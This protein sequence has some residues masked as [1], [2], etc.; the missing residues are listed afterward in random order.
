ME[1]TIVQSGLRRD[2]IRVSSKELGV[3]TNII[4]RAPQDDEDSVDLETIYD[5][6]YVVTFK[7]ADGIR[8]H[9]LRTARSIRNERHKISDLL[10]EIAQ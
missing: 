2:A 8:R 7:F 3:K 10:K 1:N 4:V 6:D 9:I 5:I